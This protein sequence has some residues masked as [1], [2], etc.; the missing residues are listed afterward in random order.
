MRNKP[1]TSE[2]LNIPSNAF[3]LLLRTF[4]FEEF[5][6]TM[7]KNAVFYLTSN[8]FEISCVTHKCRTLSKIWTPTSLVPTL[9]H[10]PLLI[11]TLNSTPVF[12]SVQLWPALR[13]HHQPA[14]SIQWRHTKDRRS[15]K[16][17]RKTFIDQSRIFEI[18]FRSFFTLRNRKKLPGG[19]EK[20]AGFNF[21]V[22][23]GVFVGF[24]SV[25]TALQCYQCGMYSDGV[26][27][28]T[29]CLNH[30]HT[31][32]IDCPSREHRY[33]IVSSIF[34]HNTYFTEIK[35]S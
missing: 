31:K 5:L 18:F 35:K 6:V 16:K 8:A 21:A 26:G 9:H 20:M 10:P 34:F 13:K 11:S 15:H 14:P 2:C 7:M 3:Y 17:L 12:S 25:V 29:P 33:C 24:F 28:I 30:T 22:C 4:P 23:F 19:T 27:S 32:L 1:K